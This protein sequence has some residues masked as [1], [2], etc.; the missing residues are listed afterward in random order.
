MVGRI[1]SHPF[2]LIFKSGY[3]E[4][5]RIVIGM[6]PIR[7]K[8]EHEHSIWKTNIDQNWRFFEENSSNWCFIIRKIERK[9]AT[10][11]LDKIRK[12]CV[13]IIYD[14]KTHSTYHNFMLCN[15]WIL[16]ALILKM[17]VEMS[18]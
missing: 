14:V 11:R 4:T 3:I 1:R 17:K 7:S 13:V 18:H 15:N 2:N 6:S 5:A 12:I 16:T 8:H 10:V 9:Y